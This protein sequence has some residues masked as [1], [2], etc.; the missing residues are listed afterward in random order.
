MSRVTIGSPMQA[1]LARGPAP[2][3]SW[4]MGSRSWWRRTRTDMRVAL[5]LVTV[6]P[7][8]ALGVRDQGPSGPP[9]LTEQ[10]LHRAYHHGAALEPDAAGTRARAADARR[11]VAAWAPTSSNPKVRVVGLSY[12]TIG[13]HPAWVLYLRHVLTHCFGG[14]GCG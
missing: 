13:P 8:L 3:L 4:G 6:L 12:G 5:A 2:V 14:P 9:M 11:I 7:V 1:L 10:M